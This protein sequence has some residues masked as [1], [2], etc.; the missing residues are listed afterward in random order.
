MAS[1]NQLSFLPDDYMERKLRRR[2]NAIFGVLFLLVVSAIGAALM[3]KERTTRSIERQKA[4][5]DTQLADAAKPIEQFKQMQEKQQV[6]AHQAELTASLLEKVPRSYIL[7]EVS[8][9]LPAGVSLL[10]FALD[11]RIRI[12]SAPAAPKTAFE[13]RKAEVDA[14]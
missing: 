11:S 4:D 1:P 3:L 6:L 10:D 9:G 14:Q 12:T 2:T 7:A 13:Q 8:N 5:L